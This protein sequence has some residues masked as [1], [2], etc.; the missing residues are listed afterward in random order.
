MRTVVLVCSAASAQ[1][2]TADESQHNWPTVP[3]MLAYDDPDVRLFGEVSACAGATMEPAL[4][5]K[6]FAEAGWAAEIG[7]PAYSEFISGEDRVF[8]A[9]AGG[10]CRFETMHISTKEVANIVGPSTG[11][12]AEGCDIYDLGEGVT[13]TVTPPGPDPVCQSE[14]GAALRFD[15]PVKV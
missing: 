2:A 10:T 7:D 6:M 1:A 5:S 13:L 3:E 15:R 12:N 14:T 8:F 4:A 9:K 11:T